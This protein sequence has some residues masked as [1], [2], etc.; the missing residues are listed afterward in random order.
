MACWFQLYRKYISGLR[1]GLRPFL[2]ASKTSKKGG[3]PLRKIAEQSDPIVSLPLTAL[4][5][6]PKNFFSTAQD[7][8][9]ELAESI[10]EL[11]ILHPI[12]VRPL[13]GVS[14]DKYEIVS[15]HR[16]KLAA[17]MAGLTVVPCVIKEMDDTEAE[18]V[19]IDANVETRQLSTMEM[20][21]S[22]RRKKELLGIRRGNPNFLPRSNPATMAELTQ[23]LAISER[24]LYRLDKLN[25]LII[26][27]QNL[28]DSG[29][30]GITLGERLASLSPDLQQTL[31][32]ALGDDI[33][34]L[35]GDEI[36]RLR[37]ENERGYM[38][39]EYYQD[40]IKELE[41]QLQEYQGKD[42]SIQDL[43][44]RLAYLRQKK[45]ELEYDII[46]RQTAAKSVEK[47]TTQKGVA[48]LQLIEQLCRPIQAARPDIDVLV[49]EPIDPGLAPHI[50]RWSDVLKE[51]SRQLDATVADSGYSLKVVK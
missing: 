10:R 31:Y 45:R 35:S 34:S 12:V 43:D 44:S 36:K 21:R 28:I 14:G 41:S 37:Q 51:V 6:N 8:L 13:S 3:V 22:I 30:L 39:L 50:K 49:S 23:K 24:Q 32:N 2:F 19:L 42:Q 18:L 27:L 9:A 26:P 11:G 25:D 7:S 17:E 5:P 47:R 1:H 16:R 33:S 40:K 38:V 29:R 48:L 20:A 46:D 4:V 15:G